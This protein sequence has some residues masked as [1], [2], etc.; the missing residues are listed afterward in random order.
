MTR[1]LPLLRRQ[2]CL[3]VAFFDMQ[4]FRRRNAAQLS[5]F[6]PQFEELR[7]F[8]MQGWRN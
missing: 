7:Q 8:Q 3:I 6:L 4:L 2:A 1:A 5:R